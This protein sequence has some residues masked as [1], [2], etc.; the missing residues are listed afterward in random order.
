MDHLSYIVGR[1][2][3]QCNQHLG[4]VNQMAEPSHPGDVNLGM[5]GHAMMLSNPSPSQLPSLLNNPRGRW[6][7]NAPKMPIQHLMILM[8]TASKIEM[9]QGELP[10]V[11]A[12]KK[13]RGDRR[14]GMITRRQFEVMT[15]L[16][17][18][19][20]RCYGFV[21][22]SSAS[23]EVLTLADSAPYW[24]N[25]SLKMRSTMSSPVAISI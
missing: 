1:I 24:K 4:N 16:L 25:I 14:Y 5:H 21:I 2:E 17:K 19:A 20:A 9:K 8:D 12:L 11:L 10:P 3:E 23:V 6:Q 18:D 22:L 13:I 15:M 7:Q